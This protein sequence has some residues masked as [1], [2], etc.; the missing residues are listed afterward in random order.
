[1]RERVMD[2]RFPENF[3]LTA[4]VTVRGR[5]YHDQPTAETR[6]RKI[7]IGISWGHMLDTALA[8]QTVL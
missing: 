7:S 1:M 8:L 2:T 6:E 5:G 3:G 4:E